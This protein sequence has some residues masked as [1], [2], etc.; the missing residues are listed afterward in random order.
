VKRCY[1]PRKIYHRNRGGVVKLAYLSFDAEERHTLLKAELLDH[2][3]NV[4]GPDRATKLDALAL[5]GI[6]PLAD[7][8]P[9]DA[10]IRAMCARNGIAY[11]KPV[12]AVVAEAIAANRDAS[13]FAFWLAGS[14]P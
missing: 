11:T 7:E 6:T 10:W 4:V 13:F 8:R 14:L 5:L 12:S 1:V 3:H 9:L 2:Q